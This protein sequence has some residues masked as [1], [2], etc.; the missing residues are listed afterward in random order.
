[1]LIFYL[2][3]MSPALVYFG[4]VGVNVIRDTTWIVVD[5]LL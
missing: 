4:E 5:S 3:Y 1:M 2:M